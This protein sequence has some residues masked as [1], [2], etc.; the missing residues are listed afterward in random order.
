L[1]WPYKRI[2]QK[3][4]PLISSTCTKFSG[5]PIILTIRKIALNREQLTPCRR[6]K[7]SDEADRSGSFVEMRVGSRVA[8]CPS[9]G[10]NTSE[11]SSTRLARSRSESSRSEHAPGRSDQTDRSSRQTLNAVKR[12]GKRFPV[13]GGPRVRCS[14]TILS[15]SDVTG[16]TT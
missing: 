14:P 11:I 12:N 7:P 4:L 3:R 5:D 2:E 13:N 8:L 10:G 6:K 1:V 15:S 16:H 9:R